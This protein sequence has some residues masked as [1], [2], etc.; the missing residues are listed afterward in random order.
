MPVLLTTEE[1]GGVHGH[2]ERISIANL[3]LGTQLLL[4]TVR[5]AAGTP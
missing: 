1:V 2:D 3:R 5:R 4:D